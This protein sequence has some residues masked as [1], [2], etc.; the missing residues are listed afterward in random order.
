MRVLTLRHMHIV[1]RL[2]ASLTVLALA[3]CGASH[4]TRGF[5]R[6]PDDAWYSGPGGAAL[7][8][9]AKK[10]SATSAADEAAASSGNIAGAVR[11]CDLLAKA[12]TRAEA[13]P[14]IPDRHS[15]KWYVRALAK[16]QKSAADCSAGASA[17]DLS[18][19]TQA[20]A[21]MAAGA[22]DISHV[23]TDIKRLVSTP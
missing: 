16:F 19:L 4:L 14:P 18:V 17:G 7:R 13:A 6:R 22:V 21:A 1:V 2:A 11:P 12:V 8:H 23:T 9:L 15:Q 3:G 20:N 10:L 5:H